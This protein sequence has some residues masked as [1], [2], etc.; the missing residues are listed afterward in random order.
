MKRAWSK[1]AKAWGHANSD[2][3]ITQA[4][5]AKVFLPSYYKY[6]SK[7]NIIAGFAK[8][9]LVPFNPDSPDYSKLKCNAAQKASVL[10]YLKE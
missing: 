7:E 3:C 2:E 1:T 10:A 4:I 9:G 5:F 6:V 8:C